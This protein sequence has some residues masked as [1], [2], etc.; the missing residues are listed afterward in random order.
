MVVLMVAFGIT[1][2]GHFY[3]IL[4]PFFLKTIIPN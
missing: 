4:A 2:L 1:G 3:N